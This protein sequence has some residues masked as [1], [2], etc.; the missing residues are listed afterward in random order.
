M[1][2]FEREDTELQEMFHGEEKPMHPD[3]VHITLNGADKPTAR[4]RAA[5]SAGTC[6]KV[7]EKQ[8]TVESPC[9]P[10]KPDPDSMEKIKQMAK[11][12]CK[13][14]ALSLILFWWQQT[15]R[16]EE[17]TAWYSLLVC[18]GMVFFSV[19]KNWRGGVK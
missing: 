6:K 15:G 3:T 18:V 9:V 1:T 13:Y 14:A 17:T 5:E 11:D 2:D 19:G 10:V 7:P 4:R 12:V 16:L 8:N